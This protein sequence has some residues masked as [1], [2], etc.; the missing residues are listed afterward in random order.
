MWAATRWYGVP[1]PVNHQPSGYGR[2]CANILHLDEPV[3]D[4][5]LHCPNGSENQNVEPRPGAL[6]TPTCPP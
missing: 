3:N 6:Q 1:L 4:R 5:Y 2:R